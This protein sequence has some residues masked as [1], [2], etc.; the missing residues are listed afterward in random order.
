MLNPR[1]ATFR[2]LMR[3]VNPP[4]ALTHTPEDES[5]EM[6]LI[7]TGRAASL[8]AAALIVLAACEQQPIASASAGALRNERIASS[9]SL[10]VQEATLRWLI[11]NKSA[12]GIDAQCVSTG[13]PAADADPGSLLLD[14]FSGSTP[15]VVPLSSCTVDV[16][17]I[18][19]NPTGGLA[20]WFKLGEPVVSGRRATLPAAMQLN[21]RL[22]EGYECKARL[23]STWTISECALT[24]A[25]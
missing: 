2:V 17:A 24:V 22:Y 1:P 16:S 6:N 4:P 7:R 8:A 11:A 13:F 9:T 5:T 21:G 18:T 23:Q 25:G 20:Q 14:R 19:Y 3:G 15:P 10:D 12:T